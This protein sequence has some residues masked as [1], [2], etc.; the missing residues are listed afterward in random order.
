MPK[1]AFTDHRFMPATLSMIEQAN[2]ILEEYAAQGMV[3]NLRQLHYQFVA[4]GISGYPNTMKSY[5]RLKNAMNDGRWAGFVD[6]DHLEDQTRHLRSL[7][8]WN[9]PA[10]TMDSISTQFRTDKWAEQHVRIEVWVEKDA[11][12][13]VIGP[14]CRQLEIPYF[15]TRGYPSA[16]EMW[17]ARQRIRRYTQSGQEA[18]ILHLGDHDPSG[19]HI[20]DDLQRLTRMGCDVVV[21]RLALNRDQVRRYLPPPNPAKES[22]SRYTRYVEDTGLTHSWELDAL[23]PHVLQSL[24]S[25]RVLQLRHTDLWDDAVTRQEAMRV[26]LTQAAAHWP[27]VTALLDD[28]DYRP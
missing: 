16:S 4:R 5:N 7:P 12:I 14:T 1:L 26:Q 8:T 22:D 28:I 18:T 10:D 3:M 13:G 21:E 17:S 23:D 24:I 11:L 15:S 19:L 6:W 25:D 20:T 27:S 9:D 2:V